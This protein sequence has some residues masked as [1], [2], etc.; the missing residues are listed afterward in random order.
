LK[1]NL[2]SYPIA[3]LNKFEKTDQNNSIL[4]KSLLLSYNQELTKHF[5]QEMVSLN[6]KIEQQFDKFFP[7]E[8]TV[9]QTKLQ[10]NFP[11]QFNNHEG[12]F[13]HLTRSYSLIQ[14]SDIIL[15]ETSSYVNP[16][17]HP[18]E[19]VLSWGSPNWF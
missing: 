19:N 6:H 8:L 10:L 13:S 3:P 11:L 17:G 1:Y 4:L 15:I 18:K 2:D 7:F 16:L 9:E 12:L 14:L 5:N